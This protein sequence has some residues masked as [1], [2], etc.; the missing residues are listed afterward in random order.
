MSIDNWGERTSDFLRDRAWNATDSDNS[1]P[2]RVHRCALPIIWAMPPKQVV[3]ARGVLCD[4]DGTLVDSTAVVEQVWSEFAGRYGL[5][6]ADVL[7]TAHGRLT[8]ETVREYAPVGVDVRAASVE[9]A[10]MELVRTE[11]IVEIPGAGELMKSLCLTPAVALVTSAP[12]ELAELRMHV[13]GVP[14]PPVSVCAEDVLHGKPNPEGYLE[15]SRLIG[16]APH[17]AVVFEDAEAGIEAALAA[18]CQVIVV[19]DIECEAAVGLP[20]VSDFR[21]VVC[22]IPAESGIQR[23][24]FI[25]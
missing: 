20:R 25:L 23:F 9:L 7:A 15:A 22:E 3:E 18:G 16:C 13:A 11:G 4:M 2:R 6:V 21:S 14:M 24:T 17:D 5:Q 1:R 8:E 10:T 12:R 19:G